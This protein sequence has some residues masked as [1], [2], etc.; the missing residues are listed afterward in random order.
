MVDDG[1]EEMVI[2]VWTDFYRKFA[3]IKEKGL[4]KVLLFFHL[5]S[6]RFLIWY[7]FIPRD[8]LQSAC[9]FVIGVPPAQQDLL[10]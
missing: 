5:L 4:D 2:R 3:E 7:C 6:A 9:G 1:Q 10:S 8:K